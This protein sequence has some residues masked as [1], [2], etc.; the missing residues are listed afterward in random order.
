MKY[1][2]R[3][4]YLGRYSAWTL[5]MTLQWAATPEF[6][7]VSTSKHRGRLLFLCAEQGMSSWHQMH[8]TGICNHCAAE[9][10]KAAQSYIPSIRDLKSHLIV[11]LK[12]L[13]C[14][15]PGTVSCHVL[16]IHS[17]VVTARRPDSLWLAGR[18]DDVKCTVACPSMRAGCPKI[19]K[20]SPDKHD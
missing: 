3:T 6:C 2:Y 8:D 15:S 16:H 11:E 19:L 12:Q 9:T 20:G 1:D 10:L 5:Q 17:C 7:W 18:S 13:G 14:V 4:M